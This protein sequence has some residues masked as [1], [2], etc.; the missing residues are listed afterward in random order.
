MMKQVLEAFPTSATR[1]PAMATILKQMNA[2]RKEERKE[3]AVLPTTYYLLPT[4]Y[5]LLSTTYYLLHATD[6]PPTKK[7]ARKKRYIITY[8]PPTI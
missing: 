1:G 4:A 6:R 3:E 5:Y 2:D 8:L 7:N